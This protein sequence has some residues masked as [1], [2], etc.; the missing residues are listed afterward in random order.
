MQ[1]MKVQD[2]KNSFQKVLT[3]KVLLI[4]LNF[5]L[6]DHRNLDMN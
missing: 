5:Y 2:P 1:T 3:N 4:F 6:Y